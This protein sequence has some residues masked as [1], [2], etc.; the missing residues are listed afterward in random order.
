MVLSTE[1]VPT[2]TLNA[3]IVGVTS[4]HRI[5]NPKSLRLQSVDFRVAQH[6]LETFFRDDE[7]ATKHWL[8]P[9]VFEICRA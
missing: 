5:E 2:E 9:Q 1:T 6:V 4:E 8:F 3:G 7:H